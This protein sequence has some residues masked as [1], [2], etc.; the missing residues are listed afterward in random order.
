MVAPLVKPTAHSRGKPN[1]SSSHA[2]AAVSSAAAT[3]DMTSRQA[4]W[5]QAA[6]SVAAPSVTGSEPPVTKPK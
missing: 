4:F 3:G 5:S 2:A 1:R 6:A